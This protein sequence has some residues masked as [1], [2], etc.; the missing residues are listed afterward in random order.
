MKEN[1]QA[2]YLKSSD[3]VDED[4]FEKI[5][6]LLVHENSVESFRVS[7]NGAL[8]KMPVAGIDELSEYK[9]YVTIIHNYI[10]A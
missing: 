1:L 4:S 5:S 8:F 7:E 6:A 3:F 10:N 2:I 9:K